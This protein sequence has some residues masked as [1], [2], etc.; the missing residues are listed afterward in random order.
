MTAPQVV[1]LSDQTNLIAPEEIRVWVRG[2]ASIMA[3]HREAACLAI[4]ERV[5]VV[6][7]ANGVEYRAAP[8]VDKLITA[9]GRPVSAAWCEPTPE[10]PPEPT[11]E[12]PHPTVL[13][14]RYATGH[15]VAIQRV[16][17][18]GGGAGNRVMLFDPHGDTVE[19]WTN[20][21]QAPLDLT[22]G[23]LLAPDDAADAIR[24]GVK[25]AFDAGQPEPLGEAEWIG[26]PPGEPT[27][28]TARIR[29]AD[30][31]MLRMKPRPPRATDDIEPLGDPP[32]AP[33]DP[34]AV[35][36]GSQECAR[37]AATAAAHVGVVLAGARL[38]DT[39][40]CD[41]RGS[42]VWKAWPKDGEAPDELLRGAIR[43]L[44][45]ISTD[46]GGAS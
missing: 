38:A 33:D 31:T 9:G 23:D 22:V 30:G 41:Y 15:M 18:P 12:F 4:R 16:V 45:K 19:E 42:E 29:L 7:T 5:P 34:P 43:I 3:A 26:A 37:A 6:Y 32:E 21:A 28:T 1:P 11:P 35:K 24:D 27:P 14:I 2:G 10:A 8:D 20:D 17:K 13:R 39:D 25:N 46:L 44:H 36:W 40:Q